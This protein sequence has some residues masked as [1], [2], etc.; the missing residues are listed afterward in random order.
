MKAQRGCRNFQDD[1]KLLNLFENKLVDI[2]SVNPT[3]HLDFAT[4]KQL[5]HK[6]SSETIR[7]KLQNGL[8]KVKKKYK[9][10]YNQQN[11][12]QTFSDLLNIARIKTDE[13]LDTITLNNFSQ[14]NN[15]RSDST[16]SQPNRMMTTPKEEKIKTSETTIGIVIKREIANIPL[17]TLIQMNI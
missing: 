16:G 6:L 10:I 4:V 13:E 2:I 12:I 15:Y 8:E 11:Y 5:L 1:K 3:Y 7:D 14:G 9:D 17:K